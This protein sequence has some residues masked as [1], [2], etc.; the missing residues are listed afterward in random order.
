MFWRRLQ[1]VRVAGKRG[2]NGH[3]GPGDDHV[4]AGDEEISS[5]GVAYSHE[6]RNDIE[7]SDQDIAGYGKSVS[8]GWSGFPDQPL[9]PLNLRPR[10]VIDGLIETQRAICYLLL[11]LLTRQLRNWTHALIQDAVA[12]LTRLCSCEVVAD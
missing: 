4:R 2:A 11:A 1:P 5:L 3:D 12:R 9:C 7:H 6:I 10:K 8:G